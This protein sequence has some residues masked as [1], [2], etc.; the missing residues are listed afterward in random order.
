MLM[1]NS[2]RVAFSKKEINGVLD[3]KKKLR[4]PWFVFSTFPWERRQPGGITGPPWSINTQEKSSYIS[5]PLNRSKR[6]SLTGPTCSQKR[7]RK[8]QKPAALSRN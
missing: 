3:G 7:N 5:T 2:V 8:M 1:K 4:T 6:N